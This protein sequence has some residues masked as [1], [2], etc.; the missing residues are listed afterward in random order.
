VLAR[1]RNEFL[2]AAVFRRWQLA[3]RIS[4]LFI[5]IWIVSWPYPSQA[6]VITFFRF[7]PMW[8]NSK[9][10]GSSSPQSTQAFFLR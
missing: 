2:S 1:W 8:S 7:M 10:I 9:T 6:I 3:Q 4:H 5:S